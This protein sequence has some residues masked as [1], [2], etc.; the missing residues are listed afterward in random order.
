MNISWYGSLKT[1]TMLLFIIGGLLYLL[2]VMESF[3][4]IKR[5]YLMERAKERIALESAGVIRRLLIDQKRDETLVVD[6]AAIAD[7][8][9]VCEVL[10]K[11]LKNF[12]ETDI[13]S[14]G[15]WFEE[16]ISKAEESSCF[17]SIDGSGGFAKVPGYERKSS[18]PIRKMEFYA[19]G[20]YLKRGETFWTRLYSDPVTHISMI[21]VVSP[22]YEGKSFIGVASVDVS[23]G[24]EYDNIFS[25]LGDSPDRY[26]I[27]RDRAGNVVTA[28][29]ELSRKVEYENEIFD[30]L[31]RLDSFGGDE[32]LV[33]KL[34][35]SS[36]EI[37]SAEAVR[38]VG[39]L[40]WMRRNPADS[41]ISFV[42]QR[43]DDPV[44]H[45]GS[46]E[47][48]F[49]FPHTGWQMLI[50]IS[51]KVVFKDMDN[52]FDA[53]VW[54]TVISSLL[55]AL[56]GYLYLRMN[57][58]TPVIS[59]SR[60]LKSADYETRLYVNSN[61]ELAS[62]AES[63]NERNR[64]LAKSIE[65]KR[66]SEKLLMQQS[67]MAAIGEM[68]DAVAHQWKQ[69]LSSLSLYADLLKGDYRDGKVDG[70][71]IEEFSSNIHMQIDHMVKT[72]ETFREFFRPKRR[73]EYFD[74]SQAVEET[75]LLLKDDLM[76]NRVDVEVSREGE[77][78]L[79]GSKNGFKHI[80]LNIL[81]NARD[82]CVQK[83]EGRCRV[84]IRIVGD[85]K[86]PRVEIED[87]AGGID[88][89]PI[90]KIFEPHFTTKEEGKGTGIGLY[91]SRQIAERLDARLDVENREKGACF[92][93]RFK[94]AGIKSES[95]DAGAE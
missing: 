67:K 58:I 2:V 42:S 26:F 69:P 85:K 14:A 38:I 8:E 75:L 37:T 6:I 60:Q 62:L 77:I 3:S 94:A 95:A 19:I 48:F 80:L 12:E 54:T 76:K 78:E 47:A 44:L 1:K 35:E 39:E 88:V 90:E 92:I 23:L 65:E 22:I 49:Y 29:S 32:R 91:M 89:S 27:L 87:S 57:I 93:L 45:E 20:R 43:E 52:L 25:T 72:L 82:A 84:T 55:F 70:N 61:D 33:R 51:Q 73:D 7:G 81:S 41:P 36:V 21:T 79:F 63:F 31:Q 4:Y 9:K 10:P 18:L 13:V 86:S 17:F 5:A 74:I 40:E 68:L 16:D 64:A 34:S 66:T 15:V 28:S 24:S 46:V 11:L 71:Y 30:R 53:I 56:F 50:G 59:L 83:G